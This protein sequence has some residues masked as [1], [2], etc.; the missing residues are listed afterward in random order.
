V[1]V[2]T[3]SAE[4]TALTRIWRCESR[5]RIVARA[6]EACEVVLGW[7]AVSARLPVCTVAVEPNR[8]AVVESKSELGVIVSG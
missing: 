3:G 1:E 4:R 6:A 8:P 7:R 2:A 5:P